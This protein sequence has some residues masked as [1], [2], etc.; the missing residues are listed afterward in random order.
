MSAK[1]LLIPYNVVPAGNMV[2]QIISPP[3]A[4]KMTDDI[5]YSL[6][7]TGAPNGI[8]SFQCSADYTPGSFPSD[9]PLNAGTWTNITLSTIITA[10]GTPD[11]A[12]V[13]LQLI[14]APWVRVVYTPSSGTGTLSVWVTGKSLS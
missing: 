2:S 1:T 8:F 4:V 5:G 12:Y 7:W 11:N 13:D 14:S 3:T 9:Y 10:S 6:A